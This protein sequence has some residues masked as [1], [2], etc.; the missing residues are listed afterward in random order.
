MMLNF[1][2]LIYS[3]KIYLEIFYQKI[4]VKKYLGRLIKKSISSCKEEIVCKTLIRSYYLSVWYPIIYANLFSTLTGQKLTRKEKKTAIF[5]S[6]IAVIFDAIFD[7]LDFPVSKLQKMIQ[8]I[9]D[10]KSTEI[11]DKLLIDFYK[12]IYVNMPSR[13]IIIFENCIQDVFNAQQQSLCQLKE[14]NEDQLKSITFSKGGNSA[15]L[16]RTLL[17][18]P[19]IKGEKSMI[20]ALGGWLQLLNDITNL[21]EDKNSGTNTIVTKCANIE[22]L[23]EFYTKCRE[24]SVNK[25]KLLNY[26]TKNKRKAIFR[27]FLLSIWGYTHIHR[28]RKKDYSSFK[29]SKSDIFFAL[30]FIKNNK[31]DCFDIK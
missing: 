2:F 9:N 14:I 13:H 25:I 10:Y 18:C 3:I 11:I 20:F 21:L 22:E 19:F 31:S 1:K 6:A 12:V 30:N 29:W 17:E 23:Q 5:A 27:I 15:L 8:N 4:L 16:F 26:S 7:D 28:F 24:D